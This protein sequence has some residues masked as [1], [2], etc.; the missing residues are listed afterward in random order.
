MANRKGTKDRTLRAGDTNGLVV[1]TGRAG[2]H[3]K[4]GYVLWEAVCLC[5]NKVITNTSNFKRGSRC[6]ACAVKV[7][8]LTHKTHGESNSPLHKTWMRMRCRCNNPNA[9][10][11]RH[12]GGKGVR[13]CDEW[14][15]FVGFRDWA[16]SHGYRPSLSIE[17]INPD[18]NYEPANCEWITCNENSRRMM[19]ARVAKKKAMIDVGT[20]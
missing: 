20:N 12:Y 18:G 6:W 2:K 4:F 11:Y 15:G 1:I 9:T 13:V 8:G 16:L 19:L 17:R 14:N 7:R 10:A 5:G 3:P